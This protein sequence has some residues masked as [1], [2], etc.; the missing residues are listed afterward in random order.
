MYRHRADKLSTKEAKAEAKKVNVKKC[1]NK[2]TQQISLI[3]G[4]GGISA[5]K[6]QSKV[7]RQ[8]HET[9]QIRIKKVNG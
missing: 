8:L 9:K 4:W 1:H 7:P 6:R 2:G 5:K 3:G